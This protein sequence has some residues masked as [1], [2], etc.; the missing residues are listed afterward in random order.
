MKISLKFCNIS[1]L[2]LPMIP[3]WLEMALGVKSSRYPAPLL[4]KMKAQTWNLAPYVAIRDQVTSKRQSYDLASATCVPNTH[5]NA[6]VVHFCYLDKRS[7]VCV[8]AHNTQ[9]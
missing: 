7:A 6:S 2:G 1:S 4:E 8:M 3:Q 9:H 5:G